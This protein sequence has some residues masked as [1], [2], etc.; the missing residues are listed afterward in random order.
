MTFNR[1][2]AHSPIP[3]LMLFAWNYAC[4]GEPATAV[5][6]LT[7]RDTGKSF[8]VRV[9][10]EISVRLPSKLGTGYGWHVVRRDR[11]C[12][13]EIQ[14]PR[15]ERSR[16]AKPGEGELQIFRFRATKP[17][18]TRLELHY[19]RPWE[20][21]SKPSREFEVGLRIFQKEE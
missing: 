20:K 15:V 7:E 13:A 21:T 17:C 2:F 1:S 19:V 9:G 18:N 12:L 3:Y 4:A 10:S 5:R 16:E 6:V 14:P 11:S 8:E